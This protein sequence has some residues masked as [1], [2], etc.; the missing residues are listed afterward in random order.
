MDILVIHLFFL[1]IPVVLLIGSI[2]G[3][4]I[5]PLNGIIFGLRCLT[6]DG[7]LRREGVCGRC[8]D[9]RQI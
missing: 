8:E 3:L 1:L 5:E 2:P 6:D 9:D 4:L 7:R